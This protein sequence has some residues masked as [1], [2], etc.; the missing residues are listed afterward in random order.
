M[1]HKKKNDSIPQPTYKN[2][3]MFAG[4]RNKQIGSNQPITKNDSLVYR[5]GFDFGFKH[6]GGMNPPPT[7]ENLMFRGGRWEGQNTPNP[8]KESTR[9]NII[10]RGMNAIKGFFN[11]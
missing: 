3:K 1:P 5:Q 11:D 7:N 6:Q 4:L 9:P 2:I 10:T 8:M